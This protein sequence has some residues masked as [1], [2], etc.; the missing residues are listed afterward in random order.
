MYAAMPAQ[1]PAHVTVEDRQAQPVCLRQDR[2]SGGTADA[3]QGD[4]RIEFA[5]QFASVMF[6]ADLR[7]AMQVAR[8]AVI[9][10]P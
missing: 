10:K 1:H 3:G 6:D 4:Q 2:A 5:R 8:A 9:T 7:G